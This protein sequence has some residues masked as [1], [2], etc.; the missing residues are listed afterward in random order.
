MTLAVPAPIT[1]ASKALYRSLLRTALAM[2]DDHRRAFVVH[3]TRAEFDNSRHLSKSEA[4]SE[5]MLEG[6]IYRDQLERQAQ[7]LSRLA[8]QETLIPVNL[9]PA[10]SPERSVPLRNAP[11][12]IAA[13]HPSSSTSR[14]PSRP[15][16]PP[17]QPTRRTTAFLPTSAS[18]APAPPSAPSA[19]STSDRRKLVRAILAREENRRSGAGLRG[20]SRF[21][22]GPEPS[23]VKKRREEEEQKKGGQEGK[24]GGWHPSEMAGVTEQTMAHPA[25]SPSS[26]DVQQTGDLDKLD[27][28][29][30]RQHRV[31]E[32]SNATQ[33]SKSTTKKGLRFWLIFLSLLLATFEAAVEQ[34]ALSTALP[35]IS[36]TLSSGSSQDGGD[37]SWIANVYMIT[38][39]AFIP[40]SG[41][42]SYIFGRRPVML[43]GL[44]L[45]SL[46]SLVCALAKDMNT[47]LAGRG[48]QGA[49]GGIILAIVEVILSDIVP[50]SERGVY[51]GAF[52]AT[53]TL[54]SA[55]GPLI[56]GAFASFDYR[57]LFWIN[58]PISAIVC[59]VVIPCVKLNNPEG[60]FR[61]KLRKM[62]WIGN[63]V[64][65]PSMSV[66]IL[67]LVWGG[68]T[69]PWRS[70]HVIAPIICGA[71]GLVAWFFVEKHWVRYP[72]VPFASLLNRTSVV[73]YLTTMLHGI[74]AMAVY[75]Y[76]PAYFQSARA[77]ST[78]ASA[79]NFLP[80]V[81]IVS[82][83]AML[84]GLSINGW[85]HYKAQNIAG[86]ILLA[87]GVGLLSITTAT[88]ST[89]G[90]VL[91]PMVSA[92]G[93]G[94][95]YAAPVFPVLAPLPPA[96]A[97]QAL[98]F[99]MLVRTFG[100][101]LG[102][103]I[104]STVLNN[105]L[106]KKLPQAF[107]DRVPEGLA[108]AYAAIPLIRQLEEPLKMQTRAAFA[109]A[110]RV[111]WLVMIPFSGIG[112]I[113]SLFMHNLP[114][115]A[116]VD[117]TYGVK[118]KK[119][120]PLDVV[121][122]ADQMQ[123]A[124]M[125][126]QGNPQQLPLP[127]AG[128]RDALF[129]PCNHQNNDFRIALPSHFPLPASSVIIIIIIIIRLPTL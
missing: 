49:G 20:R 100:N 54:A 35:T 43:A 116:E 1:A 51:Q 122:K 67:G 111:V 45:F 16:R 27:K 128:T 69:Y 104:G 81:C 55:T 56:G 30:Q 9:R 46:G 93:I 90:W 105:I 121:E 98:A 127:M 40:W 61:E 6:E 89:A 78:I 87:I 62:D 77:S 52:S 65:I 73:G 26:F 58:L 14:G 13:P 82:P 41:G 72:T 28:V 33:D 129:P 80:V 109:E 123:H 19:H 53:W 117:E 25:N 119:G 37:Y 10:P 15:S 91:I 8:A 32:D 70:A 38:S 88:T 50:L 29:A 114:L 101:V 107:I 18:P 97:G 22:E 36:S 76:W 44:G 5:R 21:M 102:I 125:N 124:A 118:T 99:Q 84:T 75:Y 4:I 110:L 47:M 48:V 66:L 31:R 120:D 42:L 17:S 85:Q 12:T 2:P 60:S 126:G 24:L 94:I 23:W 106:S 3:R 68:S 108:G 95:N 64:F 34:T 11:T 115:A 83:M 39:A 113:I 79:V 63:F 59:A 86:W 71:L 103:S 96:L 92:L 57:Y 112:F 74:V 7:H